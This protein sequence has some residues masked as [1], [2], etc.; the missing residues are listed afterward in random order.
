MKLPKVQV[1]LERIKLGI[2]GTNRHRT[3][4][5][6]PWLGTDTDRDVAEALGRTEEAVRV[7]RRK[8][9]IRAYRDEQ[10]K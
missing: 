6:D 2:P 10:R 1:Q 8:I 9:G 5:Y 7:R 3:A 4:E